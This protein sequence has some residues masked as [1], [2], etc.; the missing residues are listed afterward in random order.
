MASTKILVV[1]DEVIVAKTIISQLNQLGYMVTDTASS[2]AM[3]IAKVTETQP[4]LI[5]MDIVLKGTMDG[6]TAAAQI[7]ELVDIPIIYLTA[8]ADDSTLQR[9]KATHPFGYIVKPFTA[10]DLRVAV[11]IGLFKHQVARELQDNRDQLATLLRSMS[12]AVIATDAGGVITFMNPAAEALTEWQQDEALGQAVT[13]VFQLIDEVTET[14]AEN[15]IAK[16]LT[17]QQVSY[18]DNF[19]ALVTKTGTHIPIGDRASPLKRLS[20]EV[21]GAV[22]VFWDMSD[23][24]QS[25]LLSQALAK[26]KELNQLKSQF[27]S[28]VSHEFRNPLAIIRTAAELLEK[29]PNLTETQKN[30]YLQRIKTSV[31]SMNQLMEDVL[32]I[33]QAEADR[34][35]FQPAPLHLEQFCQDL[36]EEFSMFEGSSHSIV[37]SSQGAS[38]NAC[39]DERLLRYVLTNLLSNAIKYS[40]PS[41]TVQLI[42]RIDPAQQTATFLVQDQGIGIPESDQTRLFDS[43]F[44]AANATLI[45]GTGLGLAIVKRCVDAHSGQ[46]SLTSKV[47]IGTTISV[48]LP[49]DLAA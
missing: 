10:D 37:F 9:V 38:Q 14:P 5:L 16:V 17:S 29:K 11:E 19:T 30:A 21:L 32:F 36:A 33:G 18:L 15:P 42:L 22:V 40:Q 49:L 23:L 41:T 26:E 13:T 2:G 8:Y 7:R 45:Q 35:V 31:R 39:M 24:R 46:I 34:L 3:A 4:D 28:T 20:G 27:V 1:E 43:F 44:R 12:D 25:E 48:I 47:G 6:V